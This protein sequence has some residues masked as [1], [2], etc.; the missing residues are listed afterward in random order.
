MTEQNMDSAEGGELIPDGRNR[1][2]KNAEV[3]N[4]KIHLRDNKILLSGMPLHFLV[5]LCLKG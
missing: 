3:E 5:C 1:M 4:Y 2:N